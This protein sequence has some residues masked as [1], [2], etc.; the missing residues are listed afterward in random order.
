MCQPMVLCS[1]HRTDAQAGQGKLGASLEAV[2]AGMDLPTGMVSE[3]TRLAQH[4]TEVTRP[5]DSRGQAVCKRQS[6]CRTEEGCE[7][8]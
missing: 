1:C 5:Q 3:Q 7:Q 2:Y 4:T 8:V 6:Q